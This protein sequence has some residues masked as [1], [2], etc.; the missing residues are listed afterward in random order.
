MNHCRLIIIIM[1]EFIKLENMPCRA[2]YE[3]DDDEV[4][5]PE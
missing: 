3:D 4:C 2:C 1:Q 5:L